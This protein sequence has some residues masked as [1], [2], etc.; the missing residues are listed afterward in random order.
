[1]NQFLKD[2]FV[3]NQHTYSISSK[4]GV[5]SRELSRLLQLYVL[6]VHSLKL[7][8][9]LSFKQK[10]INKM[11]LKKREITFNDLSKFIFWIV[12]LFKKSVASIGVS[13][14]P[15]L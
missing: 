15:S 9:R 14:R 6:V 11:T 7:L 4:M 13:T 2:L 10:F 1:M 3:F 12:N 8:F 5:P